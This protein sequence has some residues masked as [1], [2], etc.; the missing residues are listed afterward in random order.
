MLGTG[1]ITVM[2]AVRVANGS[3][4]VQ[5]AEALNYRCLSFKGVTGFVRGPFI[6]RRLDGACHQ[7]PDTI[8]IRAVGRHLADDPPF[9]H[10]RNSIAES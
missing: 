7:Q 4:N 10:H 5:T 8:D 2:I 9:V 3:N 1:F 6:S